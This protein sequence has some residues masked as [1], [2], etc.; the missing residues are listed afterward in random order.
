MIKVG[1]KKLSNLPKA[2][3]LLSTRAETQA[4]ITAKSKEQPSSTFWE[5]A[6]TAEKNENED[7]LLSIRKTNPI[8]GFLND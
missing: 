7:Q 5:E 1:L 2:I 8:L 6:D 3:Q 4:N